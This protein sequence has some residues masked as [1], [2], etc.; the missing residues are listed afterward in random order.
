MYSAQVVPDEAVERR[1][2]RTSLQRG[3]HAVVVVCGGCATWLAVGHRPDG[4]PEVLLVC[5]SCDAVNDPRRA[6]PG[7]DRAAALAAPVGLVA[8]E[9]WAKSAVERV[10]ALAA[11]ERRWPWRAG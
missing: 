8:T 4:A 1:V 3:P 2:V 5:S 11:Q 10:H 9:V 6:T 7:S